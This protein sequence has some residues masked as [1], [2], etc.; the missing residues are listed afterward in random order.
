MKHL[1][2]HWKALSAA[3]LM[4]LFAFILV[5]KTNDMGYTRDES[6]YFRFATVYQDWFA[7]LG[8]ENPSGQVDALQRGNVAKTWRQNFEH[9]PLVKVLM[10]AFWRSF[11]RIERDAQSLTTRKEDKG[12][13]LKVSGLSPSH[14]FELG[15]RLLV[16]KPQTIDQAPDDPTRLLGEGR[17]VNPSKHPSCS[18]VRNPKRQ[19][20][21]HMSEYDAK[22]LSD[23]CKVYTP[24]PDYMRGCSVVKPGP[25][26]EGDAMRLV[27]PF[28]TA[29]LVFF[30]VIFGWFTLHPV[31]GV[32]APLLFLTVPRYFFHAHM[33]AFDMPVVTMIFVIAAGFWW[34]LEK[35]SWAWWTAI[36]WGIGLLTKHNAFFLPVPLVAFW[37]LAWRS[38]MEGEIRRWSKPR[39]L[40]SGL[41]VMLIMVLG[42]HHPV[43]AAILALVVAWSILHV[44]IRLPRIPLAFLLMPPI[45]MT[46]LFVFWPGLWIDP[47]KAL[48]NY[49]GF[50][51]HHEHYMQY[52]FGEIQQMPP[53]PIAF[54][55]IMTVLT[56][57][58]LTLIFMASGALDLASPTLKSGIAWLQ[59]KKRP[60]CSPRRAMLSRVGLFLFLLTAFP[61]AL[62]ALPSTPIFGGVKHWMTAMPF[63]CLIGGWGVWQISLFI[64]TNLAPTKPIL[65]YV[66]PCV[67]TLSILA[68][69]TWST[70][71]SIRAGN[72]HYNEVA[73]GV[74]GAADMRLTRLY[75]GY[76]SAIALDE[77][78]RRVKPRARVWF[79]DTTHDAYQMY[80]REGRL[81]ADIRFGC[82]TYWRKC[83]ISDTDAVL[84]EEQR[85]FAAKE[86]Q[87]K[88]T[89]E[90]A[91]PTWSYRYDGVPMISLYVRPELKE[92]SKASPALQKPVPGIG[93]RIRA[94]PKLPS[95]RPA[96]KPLHT[97]GDSP[98][99]PPKETH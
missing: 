23:Q 49:F 3:S 96:A 87:I 18:S 52:Y 98:T 80:K 67:L 4:A 71:H 59:K 68:P 30:M 97:P 24:G 37:L 95:P 41:S 10:G 25:L 76:T 33:A 53:F 44:R 32:V 35:P 16:M 90:L 89:Y 58:I 15:A 55:L 66:V 11:A 63:A 42:R 79:H 13:Y 75:W 64:C 74:P 51:L 78:N 19:A 94:L 14:D 34:S 43:A 38:E 29:I 5:L 28:F 70:A 2:L 26:T 6:F 82:P 73:G 22:A 48:S 17:I 72:A 31:A 8:N 21:V 57:P 93:D 56:V 99:S 27:G 54:P 45:G 47:F 62:I 40:F 83:K 88:D 84:F 92:N 85:F 36:L 7:E 61:I 12:A 60:E 46:M 39:L 9:P 50:H 1:R 20:C 86:L 77:L 91:G 69:A 65:R 81:R